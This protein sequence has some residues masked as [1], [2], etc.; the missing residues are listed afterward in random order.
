MYNYMEILVPETVPKH[1]AIVL[2]N[3]AKHQKAEK[4][5]TSFVG[6]WVTVP[7]LSSILSICIQ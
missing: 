3:T 5:Q 1:T 6:A 2:S 7:W 4:D